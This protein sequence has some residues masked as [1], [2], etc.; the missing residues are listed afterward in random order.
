MKRRTR[1]PDELKEILK[2]DLILQTLRDALQTIENI[3]V[4][5]DGIGK[6]VFKVY[7]TGRTGRHESFLWL[8]TPIN[9]NN[10][11]YAAWGDQPVTDKAFCQSLWASYVKSPQKGGSY[12]KSDV[13]IP[14][15][16]RV[17]EQYARHCY[18]LIPPKAIDIEPPPPDR[19]K[20]TTNRII[21]DT[22][23][24][25]QIKALHKYECQICGLAI[26]LLDGTKYAEAHH[27]KPLGSPHIGLDVPGNIIVLCPNH[28]A[29]CDLGAILL[30]LGSLKSH[31]EHQIDRQYIDYHNS[32]IYRGQS[33]ECRSSE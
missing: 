9:E 13:T 30:D 31:E 1:T 14:T 33:S 8:H 21:R 22:A 2:Q 5:A 17:V 26:D 23:L 15:I 27:I 28:H 20:T 24:A 3:E 6:C 11:L 18:P 7:I 25:Q 19:V 32:S 4:H 29:M 10:K 16:I 12:L